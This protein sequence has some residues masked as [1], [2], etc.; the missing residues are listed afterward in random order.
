VTGDQ[1]REGF[2]DFFRV[3]GHT[4][5]PSASLVPENDPSLMFT[6][7]GMVRFKQVFLG[8]EAPRFVRAVDS[9][10]CLRI[11]GKHN[12]LEQVGRDTYH[13]TF[14]EMLG[15]WSF[16]DYYKP[17]AIEWAWELLTA[18]WK[19]PKD[20]L[21]A[22][23]HTTDDEAAR[24]WAE[25]TDIGR[26]RILRFDAE[27]FWEMGETG[28]CGP[29]SEIHIDRGPDACD[30]SGDPTH[31]CAVN[32]G[33]A[34]YIELWNLVFIQY[35]RD[36]AGRLTDLPA[37]HVDTG[38]GFE[39]I[40][41]VL[42]GVRDNYQVDVLRAVVARAER[43]TGK[44]YGAAA[45]DD[46]SLRVIADHARAVTFLVADGILPSNE[47]R[48]YVLRRLLRRAARHGKLLGVSGPFLHQVV[49]A[50]VHAMGR[51]YPELVTQ[52]RRIAEV[53]RSEEERFAATLDRG[54][55]LL[56]GEV[57]RARRGGGRTLPGEVA[58]R[59]YDTYGFPLDLTE[60]I[61]AAEGLAVD[62][63]GFEREM[64]AQ[65]ARAR[66]AQR[67]V[68]AEGAQ[69]TVVGGGLATR[70]VG[71]H[72]AEWESQVL[73]LLTD[74]V[75]TRG[76]VRTGAT[77]DVVTAETPFYAES[78]GQVGDR[79]WLETEAGGRVEVTDTQKIAPGV[80]AHRG[81]VR[82]GALA[83]GDRVRLRIDAER[84]EAAR[85]NHSATHLLHAA[86]RRRLGEHVKQAGSLVTPDRLRFDFSHHRPVEESAL[87]DIEDETNAYVRANAEVWTEEMPYDEA[88]K[89]GALAFFGD[90]YGDRV[91]VVRMGD[92]SVELCGGTHVRRTGDIGVV[93]IRDESG[94]AAGVRRL[95]AASGAGALELIRRQEALLSDL[96]ELLKTGE[97]EAKGRLEKLLA[98][99]RELEKRI[100]EL[101]GKLAGG[102]SRDVL[103]DARH[104]DGITVLATRVEGL[105]D[106]GLR[107][108][109][110]RL[111]DRIK[112][113]VVVLGA[114]QGERALLLAAVTKDLTGRFHAGNIIKQLAPLVGGGGGGRPDFAQ[115]G[116]KD[117][118]RLDEALAAAYDLLGAG[119]R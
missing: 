38:M 39:R 36:E 79:G 112:S 92:F 30:R 6:N 67:F 24:L 99:K 37:K 82:E 25:H 75:E 101:Q 53:V 22:T 41:T 27:N 66:G 55:A 17:E 109:A 32:G 10:K 65:R 103:A 28:P 31:R 72:V 85:L 69:E 96:S 108:L 93:K 34:R 15:N 90:K 114:A 100:A 89:A 45:R 63:A 71:D 18:V 87:R 58:F 81:V 1:I 111:R 8:N 48:G 78:G 9:Q 43:L 29:C 23:V 118:A 52:H 19:L 98:E 86:L 42:Q 119:S 91:T 104:I 107:E 7:A 12:D 88:I 47:G 113:G 68:D 117:P 35:N 16:G 2:L 62:R 106:K 84:R 50:V 13:H 64:E 97:D 49:D 94:V 102:A 56:A 70:F 4:V 54:L 26:D 33:C 73:A 14:F 40:C 3:R 11:S 5:V 61:L 51:A 20:R 77:V 83:V 57:E 105:D 44:R 74:G 80:V 115:A 21:Y 60:D 95:E 110:D 116:G 76:P 46:V 59:L